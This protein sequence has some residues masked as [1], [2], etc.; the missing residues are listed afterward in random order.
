MA[1][2]VFSY[3]IFAYYFALT[4]RFG[5]LDG[6]V[7][8]PEEKLESL[9]YSSDANYMRTPAKYGGGI[10]AAVEVFHQMHC[11]VSS[12]DFVSPSLQ[13]VFAPHAHIP[14]TN[15][16]EYHVPP[17]K[18]VPSSSLPPEFPTDIPKN[19]I[20]QYTYISSYSS[21]PPGFNVSPEIVR[22]HIDHCI[23]TLRRSLMCT[24]DAT[25]MPIQADPDAPTGA[26]AKFST[27]HKCRRWAKLTEWMEKNEIKDG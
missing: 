14:A 17:K 13:V 3:F 1:P 2:F 9:N 22:T 12:G 6:T 26:S 25:P 15:P 27:H 16:S 23:E 19:M 20:R 18:F 8:V 5:V 7:N 21:P 10:E 11:L 24:G 4:I